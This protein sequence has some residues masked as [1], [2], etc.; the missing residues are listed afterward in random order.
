MANVITCGGVDVEQVAEWVG[1]ADLFI[2][3][4][5]EDVL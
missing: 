1:A 2:F 5:V 4:E 3:R